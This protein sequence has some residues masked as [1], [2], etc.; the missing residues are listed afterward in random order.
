MQ[1]LSIVR[2]AA[3]VAPVLILA[4]TG[5]SASRAQTGNSHPG[6][7]V[8][9]QALW[10]TP[11]DGRLVMLLRNATDANLITDPAFTTPVPF[12][13]RVCVTNFVGSNN[14]MNLF[15]WTTAGPQSGNNGLAPPLQYQ[16]L[17]PGLGDCVEIDEPAAIVAQDATVSGSASGY[18]QLFEKTKLPEGSDPPK[19]GQK[20]PPEVEIGEAISR[21][22]DCTKLDPPKPPTPPNA[23]FLKAC[24]LQINNLLNQHGVRICTGDK[25]VTVVDDSNKPINANYPPGYLELTARDLRTISKNS[26]YNYNW[27]P[28]TTMSCRDVIWQPGIDHP[29][30]SVYVMVGPAQAVPGY[31]PEKVSKITVTTQAI[32]LRETGN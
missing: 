8:D 24:E 2:S 18:Y 30:R 12:R 20:K 29:A 14:A 26:D 25:F 28:V 13:V 10:S 22:F 31:D 7:D 21:T 32:F 15:V 3:I 4:L 16:V 23:N 27:N 9:Q 6:Q 17:H 19:K 11:G 1:M 5:A